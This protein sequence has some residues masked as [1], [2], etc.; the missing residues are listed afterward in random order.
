MTKE[1]CNTSRE[2]SVQQIGGCLPNSTNEVVYRWSFAQLLLR[3]LFLPLEHE[4]FDTNSFI[5][6]AENALS[7]QEMMRREYVR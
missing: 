4:P 3:L 5:L 7:R 1:A 6:F 2:V